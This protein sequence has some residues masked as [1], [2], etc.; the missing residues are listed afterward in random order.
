MGRERELLPHPGPV[1]RGPRTGVGASGAL[2]AAIF[3]IND[4]LV[5]NVALIMGFA[6]AS[7][8]RGLI[9]LAGLAGLLAGA[10][11][12]AAGEYVSVRV[13]RE[14]LER[15]LHIEAHEI[16]TDLEAEREELAEIYRRKG[17]EDELARAV[18]DGLMRDPRV[19]L[20]TH[21][22]EELGLDPARGLSSPWAAA[23]ASFAMFAVG[24]VVPLLPFLWVGGRTGALWSVG[25]T[26]AALAAVGGLASRLT[27]RPI[28]ISAARML[29]IGMSAALVTYLVGALVG[30]TVVG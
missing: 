30:T 17:L 10:S 23:G 8:P 16:G 21:A 11:S 6:G 12:M 3:G 13:Q 9:L 2:R 14:L 1:D 22:R 4:G 28:A 15:L 5:S 24:A 19:A 27:G 20:E 7:Q 26:G 18:A 25:L 29:V